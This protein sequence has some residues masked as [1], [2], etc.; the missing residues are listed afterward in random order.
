MLVWSITGY[1]LVGV[2]LGV[3]F[4]SSFKG[5]IEE[6]GLKRV[7]AGKMSMRQYHANLNL[8]RGVLVLFITLLWPAVLLYLIWYFLF[9][10]VK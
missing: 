9:A 3:V 1:L 2:F 5:M 8:V 7:A 10:E 4:I 6:A